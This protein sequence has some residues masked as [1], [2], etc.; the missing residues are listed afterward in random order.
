MLV[1]NFPI[2]WWC[3][4]GEV[5][6]NINCPTLYQ[7]C[8]SEI[9]VH[10]Y[11]WNFY[12]WVQQQRFTSHKHPDLSKSFDTV[13]QSLDCYIYISILHLPPGADDCSIYA[14]AQDLDNLH[15]CSKVSLYLSCLYH[16]FTARHLQL[17][18]PKFSATLFIKWTK[19]FGLVRNVKVDDQ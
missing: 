1:F 3:W 4:D 8:T 14:S 15:V 17:Q 12:L 2:V 11:M 18:P 19:E 7:L 10:L 6:R 9:P 16:F 13:N 5:P